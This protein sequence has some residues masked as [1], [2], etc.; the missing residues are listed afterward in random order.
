M[1][2]DCL[3]GVYMVLK[4]ELRTLHIEIGT[5]ETKVV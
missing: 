3:T 1:S 2:A 4:N 5:V